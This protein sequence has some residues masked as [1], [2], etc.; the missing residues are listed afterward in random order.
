V[1]RPW[2]LIEAADSDEGRLELRRRGDDWLLLVDGRVLMNSHASRSEH[3]LAREALARLRAPATARVMVGGLGMG[4]TL[5]A[6]LDVLPA[7]AH[8][9]VVE[10]N[11]VVV[12]WNQ[13]PLAPASAHALADPRVAVEVADV[14]EVIAASASGAWDAIVVDLYEG[15]HAATQAPDDPLYGAAALARTRAALAPGGVWAVWSEE[16]D[17]AFERRARKAGFSVQRL[18]SGEGGR[19]HPIY[20]LAAAPR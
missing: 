17:A 2:T 9:V 1:T 19:R 8:V 4:L 15:P 11:E 14:A 12:R 13:G 7:T 20:L 16:P 3:A 5:R 6:A 18:R 10:L